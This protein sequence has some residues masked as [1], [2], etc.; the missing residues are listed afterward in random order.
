MHKGDLRLLDR[1]PNALLRQAAR[2]SWVVY[3]K[4]PFAGPKIESAIVEPRDDMKQPAGDMKSCETRHEKNISM[5]RPKVNKLLF[6]IRP[7][8]QSFG[9][10]DGHAVVENPRYDNGN[11]NHEEE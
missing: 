9:N 5:A 1:D 8:N 3:S 2:K 6:Q 10:R 7:P 4:Q 11:G